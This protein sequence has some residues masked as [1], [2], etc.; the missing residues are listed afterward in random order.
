M[1]HVV[2]YRE[3][4]ATLSEDGGALCGPTLRWHQRGAARQCVLR[5]RLVLCE[6]FAMT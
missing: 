1:Q 4:L 3:A 6:I 5:S 2:I